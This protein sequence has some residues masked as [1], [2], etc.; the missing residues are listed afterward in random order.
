MVLIEKTRKENFFKNSVTTRVK[1]RAKRT[2]ILPP[3]PKPWPLLLLLLLLLLSLLPLA[4]ALRLSSPLVPFL[5]LTLALYKNSFNFLETIWFQIL[6]FSMTGLVAAIVPETPSTL[7][8]AA[9]ERVAAGLLGSFGF[10]GT[11]G[12]STFVESFSG[13]GVAQKIRSHFG[14]SKMKVD[15]ITQFAR[16]LLMEIKTQFEKCIVPLSE[17]LEMISNEVSLEIKKENDCSSGAKSSL[18]EELNQL[19]EW[20]KKLTE[21]T[22]RLQEVRKEF[23]ELTLG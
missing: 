12:F 10:G 21:S 2:M 8:A 19:T 11:L 18:R 20:L 4:L 3:P 13:V 5:L 6:F 1:F 15:S 17:R 7:A 22:K 14:P 9:A 23:G 16:E